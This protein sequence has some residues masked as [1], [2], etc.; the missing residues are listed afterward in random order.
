MDESKIPVIVGVGQTNDRDERLNAIELMAAAL[1]NA[2]ADGGGG[3]L[4]RANTLDVVAQLSFPEFAD[5]SAPLAQILGITPRHCAQTRYPMGDSPVALLNTAANRIA[6][7]EA[8]IC[9]VAGG[10]ALRT[11]AKRAAGGARDAVRESAARATREGRARY[12]IVAPTD[13]YP[14]YENA[15]RAAW[16]QTLSQAQRESAD[17]WSGFSR[18]ATANPN[19]W[20]R[21]PYT[22]EQILEV[23]PSNRPIAFPY[24]KLMVANASVNQGAAFIVTSLA[25]AKAGGVAEANLVYVGRGAA[26]REPG[27]VLARDHVNRSPSL[28]ASLSGALRFNGLTSSDLDCVELYSCFPVMPKLARRAIDWPLDSPMTVFGG[29]TFG[30][31]PVGNYMSHA[32]ASMTE[33]LRLSG[34]H[35]LLFGNGGFATTSHSIIISR[36]PQIATQGVHDP[37]V[38]DDADSWREAA[39]T[40]I[41]TYSGEATLE[42]YTIFY[43]REGA[44]KSGVIVART[45]NDE[46][47][48]T[49]AGRD[50]TQLIT[51]L[52]DGAREPVG[53]SG[54]ITTDAEGL[55]HWRL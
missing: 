49:F 27:D 32:I 43:D 30:G 39:P 42:T 31:G 8:D 51:F 23:S 2:D 21:T 10:E 16:G 9:L 3:W 47:T 45:A 18:V 41:E 34:T 50:D 26:A 36:D 13:V 40:L 29:L 48:L 11:A 44:P 55:N 35:G 4:G 25:R 24:T 38:Q 53:V 15:C 17:I 46:R 7:G 22:S 52:T 33:A 5:A 14:F 1:R 19:A 6:A 54:Q 37:S 28:E 12:G 20:L